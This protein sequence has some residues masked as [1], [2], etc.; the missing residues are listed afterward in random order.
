MSN[1]LVKDKH[2]RALLDRR[3]EIVNTINKLQAEYTAIGELLRRE[4]LRKEVEET[5]AELEEDDRR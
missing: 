2:V 4:H 3:E 1:E 5:M